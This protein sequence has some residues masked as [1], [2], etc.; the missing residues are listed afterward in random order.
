MQIY[1]ELKNRPRYLISE[2][3]PNR[4]E[5]RSDSEAGIHRAVSFE[6]VQNVK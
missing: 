2:I 4:I 5:S 3:I 1:E 6:N